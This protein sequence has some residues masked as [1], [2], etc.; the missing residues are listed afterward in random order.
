MDNMNDNEII[1]MHAIVHGRVQGV[2]F[3]AVTRDLANQLK[4]SGTVRNLPGQ[5]VEIRATGTRKTLESLLAL[6]KR[7][8]PGIATVEVD[9]H[10]PTDTFS[11]FRIVY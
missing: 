10:P 8:M 7:D 11:G 9:Y 5:S 3:R 4:L 2:G 6:L 1:Q